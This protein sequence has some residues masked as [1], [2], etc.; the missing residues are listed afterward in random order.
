MNFA[1]HPSR[2]IPLVNAKKSPASS[3][4]PPE[5]PPNEPDPT[6]REQRVNRLFVTENL[7]VSHILNDTFEGKL[8]LDWYSSKRRLNPTKRKKVVHLVICAVL[9]QFDR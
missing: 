3:N 7:N 9:R 4:A 2:H 8:V 5:T 1:P 6:N